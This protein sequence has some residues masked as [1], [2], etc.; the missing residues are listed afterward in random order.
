MAI[1]NLKPRLAEVGK[2]KI[3]GLGEER[4]SKPK[5]GEKEGRK[6]NLPVRYN[7]FVVTTTERGLDKNLKPDTE[8][9]KALGDYP[10]ELQ[11][12]LLF[13]DIDMNF[14]TS[15]SFYS[16][17]KLMCKG[18]G[19]TAFR[20]TTINLEDIKKNKNID[21]IYEKIQVKCDPDTC[22]FY[23]AKKCKMSGIL[24]CLLTKFPSFGGCYR[25]R[26]TSFNSINNILAALEFF[27]ANTN[28][29]LQGIK[30]KLVMLK[31]DT[32]EH[33]NVT[34]VGLVL[35]NLDTMGMRQLAYTEATNRKALGVNM[36][37]YEKHQRALGFHEETIDKEEHI[38]D[39][40][41]P[42]IDEET[43]IEI[44]QE[45]KKEK[46]TDSEDLKKQIE[47]KKKQELEKQKEME[48]NAIETTVVKI[49]K[50]VI[51]KDSTSANSGNNINKVEDN[52]SNSEE[53]DDLF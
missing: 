17:R 27:K 1:K 31:K 40:Y 42:E 46:G 52:T 35:D 48:K 13:D 49:E 50:P 4:T 14:H 15:L 43:A 9:M 10:K 25:F 19:E 5:Y 44:E 38:A 28:G 7:S 12:M 16:G 34:T 6:Y 47:A 23:I 29:I 21:P 22:E 18:D 45:P 20:K 36:S 11:I 32:A 51:N 30:L 41:F 26:T 37:V 8:I 33:G 2:I 3:G 24:S 39:E 53:K